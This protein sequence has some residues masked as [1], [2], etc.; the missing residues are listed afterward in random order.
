MDTVFITTL[1]RIKHLLK[2]GL[3]YSVLSS[4]Y[5]STDSISSNPAAVNI[6]TGTGALQHYLQNKFG[7]KNNHGIEFDGSWI[8]D[9]N[10]LFS[11]GIPSPERWTNNSAFLLNL[12]VDTE[13]LMGWKGGLFGAELL[14]FN[15]QNT[16]TQAGV[17]QGYN[18]LP[19]SPPF[20][21]TE[22]YQFWFRQAFLNN[23]LFIRI[24]KQVPTIDFG[25]VV[26]PI[27]LSN[28]NLAIP[29]VSGLIYTPVFLN[30]TTIGVLPG[31]YNSIYGITFSVVP[32]KRWYFLYGLYDG[33]LA[34]GQQTGNH[35]A[36]NFNGT[37]FH[38]A[39]TGFDWLLGKNQLPGDFGIG[40]WHQDGL[41]KA[42]A[43]LFEKSASGTYLFATQRLW[44]KNPGVNNVGISSF[45]Q[46]GINNSGVLPF[47][48]YLGAGLT[49]FGLIP[50][51]I[52][53]SLGAGVALSWLNQKRF[54]RAT[55]LM[56]QMY[57][58]SKLMTGIYLE[59]VIS[60]I[61]TPGAS[62]TLNSAWAGTLR[63]IVL[64]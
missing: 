21:R 24:G 45:Y 48:R 51:R 34:Q 5:A 9:T 14:Q 40:A 19:A 64:F 59:P 11:G 50:T 63:L 61:P 17:L 56:Y 57:Y 62:S 53:D 8:A 39:E 52:D 43:T 25:N 35:A 23:K 27:P 58:Q 36:P 16:N 13:K 12:T 42:S 54:S 18:S 32:T 6:K 1:K 2:I 46:Y 28:N 37:Y 38:I 60:Y 47:K 26:R 41:I 7:I 10:Y 55:E 29:A 15:G 31:F 49:G 20:N 44:Y 33:S 4:A 22:L 30:S 3:I